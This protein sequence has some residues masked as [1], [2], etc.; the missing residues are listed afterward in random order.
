LQHLLHRGGQTVAGLDGAAFGDF[1][2]IQPVRGRRIER[3]EARVSL[4]VGHF[5]QHLLGVAVLV[6]EVEAFVDPFA[7]VE[8]GGRLFAG[9]LML[10]ILAEIGRQNP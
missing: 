2:G 8:R 3:A 1:F 7:R 4:A 9:G 10:A 5:L 6:R